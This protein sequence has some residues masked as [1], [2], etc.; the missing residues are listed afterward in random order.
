LSRSSDPFKNAFYGPFFCGWA[1]IPPERFEGHTG[2]CFPIIIVKV[3]KSMIIICD[4][5]GMEMGRFCI[6]FGKLFFPALDW[7]DFCIPI[8]SDWITVVSNCC[9]YS[10][11]KLFFMDGPYFLLC[12]RQNDNVIINAVDD[13]TGTV[14]I[15]GKT[16]FKKMQSQ[17]IE[18]AK[19][20][21][22]SNNKSSD[23]GLD[24][25]NLENALER[26]ESIIIKP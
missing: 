10:T 9:N 21:L 7:E 14:V 22:K 6:G 1:T 11:F 18:I 19:M 23:L 5:H 8:I 25:K 26:L 16:S 3:I 13:H 24:Y 12:H 4:Y 15:N 2:D 17:L 20:I